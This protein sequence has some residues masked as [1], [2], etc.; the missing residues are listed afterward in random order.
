M[1]ILVSVVA[2]FIIG[3]M[4]NRFIGIALIVLIFIAISQYVFPPAIALPIHHGFE[5]FQKE[6][7][8]IIPF[9]EIKNNLLVR[10]QSL[11]GDVERGVA[12]QSAGDIDELSFLIGLLFGFRIR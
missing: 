4:F 8:S 2:G 12:L 9:Q 6:L 10:F 7:S 11:F 1:D 5:T 3:Y